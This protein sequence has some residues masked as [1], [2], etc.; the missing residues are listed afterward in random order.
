MV[1]G[2]GSTP[3][4]EP[5]QTSDSGCCSITPHALTEHDVELDVQTFSALGNETRYEVLRLLDAADQEVCAC[6]LDP[7]LDVNQ[8]T[9]SR[10]LKALERAGLV[11]RRKD[12]RWR[13]YEP[14][15]RAE[16][17]LAAIDDTRSGK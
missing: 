16:K 3:V 15:P 2:S 8:S 4:D 5:N 10:A 13:F 9:T 17:L 11:D 6:D 1:T 14:T 7:E 12:G